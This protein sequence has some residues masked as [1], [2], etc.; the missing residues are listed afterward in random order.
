MYSLWLMLYRWVRSSI[1]SRQKVRIHHRPD[2]SVLDYTAAVGSTK[3]GV[4]LVHYDPGGGC[5]R[6]VGNVWRDPQQRRE[7]T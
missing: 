3:E 7:I 5:L 1:K 2:G 4:A 6:T